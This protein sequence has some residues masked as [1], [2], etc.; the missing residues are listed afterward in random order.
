[1]SVGSPSGIDGLLER[2]REG[3]ERIEAREAHDVP[4]AGRHCWWTSATPPFASG[5]R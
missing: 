5:T 3:Y 2:V 4:G 1:M